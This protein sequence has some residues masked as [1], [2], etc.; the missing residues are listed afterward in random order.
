LLGTWGPT[1]TERFFRPYLEKMWG[2]ALEDIPSD[3]GSRF[4]PKMD[5]ALVGRGSSM[6]IANYGYN[7]T[8]SYPASGRIG[9]F[10]EALA[11]KLRASLL[12][13]AEVLTVDV[14]R[15]LV[16][17]ADGGQYQYS[18]LVS[19]LPLNS[20][21]A[22]LGR[23]FD[24]TYL[25]HSNLLNVRVGFLGRLH[26]DEHWLYLPDPELRAFRV[27]L[28]RNFSVNT[29]PEGRISLSLEVGLGEAVDAEESLEEIAMQALNYLARCSVL[30]FDAVDLV[31][32]HLISPAYV[33]HRLRVTPYLQRIS[34]ELESQDIFLAGR[35]G[36]WDYISIE[37]AYLSGETAARRLLGSSPG[38]QFS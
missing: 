23:S 21:L 20:F 19:T 29:C 25:V 33:A 4:V 31:D 22:M 24:A 5:A 28:P 32:G 7:S 6:P 3:W 26:R 30:H 11:S 14:R 10:P 15:K 27:G 13:D 1:L 8:I 17:L 18:Q 36:G 35:Y 16:I 9:D 2:R 12:F 34:D 38:S 37:E